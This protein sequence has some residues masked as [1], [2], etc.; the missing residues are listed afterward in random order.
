MTSQPQFYRVHRVL[1]GERAMK[2]DFAVSQ[3]GQQVAAPNGAGQ[4]VPLFEA[5]QKGCPVIDEKGNV[6]NS[7]TQQNTAMVNQ[8]NLPFAVLPTE[9]AAGKMGVSRLEMPQPQANQQTIFLSLI[10]TDE[11]DSDTV[12]VFDAFGLNAL[13]LNIGPPKTTTNVGGTFGAATLSLLKLQTA[14]VAFD[15]HHMHMQG[16]DETG[17]LSDAFFTLGSMYQCL[18]SPNNNTQ[19]VN[20]IVVRNLVL[21]DSFQTAIRI[22]PNYRALINPYAGLQIILPP[23]TGVTI[24]WNLSAFA[25]ASAM[26][27]YA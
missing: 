11:K 6:I 4:I 9:G 24:T 3:D 18:A 2:L 15:L 13:R 21:P 14:S 26:V 12:M 23:K 19:S 10:N 27:K 1:D 17:A 22:D 20:Q 16:T 25:A 8:N 7:Q 5:M